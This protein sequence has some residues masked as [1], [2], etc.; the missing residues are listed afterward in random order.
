[1][2]SFLFKLNSSS[3]NVM[4]IRNAIL[5]IVAVEHEIN[6]GIIRFEML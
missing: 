4:S 2:K 3:V 6:D 5:G 1:M